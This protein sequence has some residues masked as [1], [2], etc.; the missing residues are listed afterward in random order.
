MNLVDLN[1]MK[2]SELSK[3]AKEFKI[4][5]FGGLKKQDLIF[6]LLQASVEESGQVYGEGTIIF[7]VPMIFMCH[8][9]RSGGLT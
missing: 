5:G 8:L 9:P 2:I 1:K 7:P 4:Q 3:L 6:A